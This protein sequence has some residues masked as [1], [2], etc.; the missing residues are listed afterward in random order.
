MDDL[1]RAREFAIRAHGD[2]RYGPHPYVKH[3]DH[4]DQVL[5]RFGHEGDVVLRQ[6]AYLHD[7][8]EDT[9]IGLAVI[10]AEFGAEVAHLVD[11]VTDEDPLYPG[12]PRREKKPRTYQKIRQDAR[13]VLLKLADRLA[14]VEFSR[15]TGSSLLR[16]YRKEHPALVRA[17]YREGEWEDLWR[18]LD[19][20]LGA[21]P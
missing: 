12:E 4:V 15:E 20:A 19:E 17:L 13:A 14:N 10:E 1:Q 9:P 5:V 11:G 3:L 16:M 21:E 7:V 6:A 8:V 18:A 2:Q